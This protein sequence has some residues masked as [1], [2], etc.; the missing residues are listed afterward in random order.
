[1]SVERIA[2]GIDDSTGAHAALRWVAHRARTGPMRVELVHAIEWYEAES[3]WDTTRARL[4]DLGDLIT[5]ENVNAT[6]SVTLRAGSPKQILL[7][8]SERSDLLVIGAHR[9]RIIRSALAGSLPEALATLAAVPTVVVADDANI[10]DGDVVLGIA[11]GEPDP[12]V[13]F[14]A[15]EAARAGST[16]RLVSAWQLPI[17]MGAHPVTL[18][19]RPELFREGA[20]LELT[21]A[22]AVLRAEAP[23]VDVR[24]LLAE[25]S[26]ARALIEVAADAAL[27][28]V[29]R[30][31][32]TTIGGAVFGSTA[33]DLFHR[34]RT[35]VCVVPPTWQPAMQ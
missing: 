16:V 18:A 33:R 27:I 34:T 14:S 28:V 3:Y 15:R 7:D 12:P 31:H 4:Q 2:V 8:A 32:R 6:V 5:A 26:P 13:V 25:G 1:M 24:E 23:G 35:P 29:G 30:K 17:P 10:R 11:E 19:E 20:E 9:S 21:D 22:T